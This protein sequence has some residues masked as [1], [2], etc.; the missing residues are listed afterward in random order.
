MTYTFQS[1]H[2]ALLQALGPA[3]TT[4]NQRVEWRRGVD[5]VS[6]HQY[7]HSKRGPE[8]TIHHEPEGLPT[9]MRMFRFDEEPEVVTI[10]DIA[11][12]TYKGPYPFRAPLEVV[13]EYA[14]RVLAGPPVAEGPCDGNCDP[15]VPG[16]CPDEDDPLPVVMR[17]RL[18]RG[19]QREVVCV[20]GRAHLPEDPSE[21]VQSDDGPREAACMMAAHM[22]WAVLEILDPGQL[23][24]EELQ[25]Q[26]DAHTKASLGPTMRDRVVRY[27]SGRAAALYQRV[28]HARGQRPAGAADRIHDEVT[29]GL[30]DLAIQYALDARLFASFDPAEEHAAEANMRT[31]G[32]TPPTTLVAVTETALDMRQELERLRRACAEGLP[33]ELIRCPMCRRKHIDGQFGEEF[34]TRPHHTHLC[35]HCAHLWDSKR[36]SFG[37]A[38]RSP[39]QRRRAAL[40]RKHRTNRAILRDATRAL[41]E[42]NLGPEAVAEGIPTDAALDADA[43]LVATRIRELGRHL[44]LARRLLDKVPH[45]EGQKRP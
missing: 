7:E 39:E 23:S 28:A 24:R 33:R 21:W 14:Q 38:K 26:L 9:L 29:S 17:V 19:G 45:Q 25:A 32:A 41:I 36:W 20:G 37:A 8:L 6:L 31:Y 4:S 34:A 16:D 2:L 15:S 11:G 43:P 44:A 42:A 13:I 10:E 27:L 12:S 22:R 1:L 40:L 3:T 30:E 18:L 35:G 5:W